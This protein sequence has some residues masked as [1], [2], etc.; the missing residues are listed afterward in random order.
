MSETPMSATS[1]PC[2]SSTLAVTGYDRTPTLM[3][4]ERDALRALASPVHRQRWR[5]R[6]EGGQLER[7]VTP[8]IDALAVLDTGHD[9]MEYGSADLVA[10]ELLRG[11]WRQRAA[12]WGWSRE[13]WVAELGTSS[14]EAAKRYP[15]VHRQT[16][17]ATAYVLGCFR[18]IWLLGRI[19]RQRLSRK[20]F[21]SAAV[22]ACIAA[23][24]QVVLSWG[25]GKS[26]GQGSIA[27]LALADAILLSGSPR[28]TDMTTDVLDALRR[29][30]GR[31]D[32]DAG[33]HVLHRVLHALEVVPAP[34]PPLRPWPITG[35]DPLW[36]EWVERWAR[37]STNQRATLRSMRTACLKAGRW[38]A[39]THP[40]VREPGEWTRETCA[41]WVAAVDR[42]RIGDFSIR[43]NPGYG[44]PVTAWTKAAYIGIL[45]AFLSDCQEWGWI[46]RR[47]DPGRALVTPRAVR[48]SLGPNPRVIDDAIWAKLLWAG[49][50]LGDADLR[51]GGH[52]PLELL[53]ALALCWLFSGSRSN[54]IVRLR[55]GCVRWQ[56][57]DGGEPVCLLDIPVTKTSTAFT[58]P[59]DPILGRALEEWERKR[60]AQPKLVD[61][62]TGER[63]AMLFALR[64]RPVAKNYLN[65]R[66]IPVL[67]AKAGVPERD[68]RGRI[69]SHRARATI[70]SHL[71]NAKEPL[72]LAELQQWLGHRSPE[73]TQYYAQL[74]P[75]TLSRAYRDAGYF[76]RNLRTIEVLI[77]RDAVDSGAA[78]SGKPW[79]YFDLGHG[80]C[81]YTFF[82]QCPH[83][84]ACARCDFYRPKPATAALIAEGRSNLE[85][86]LK[87]VPLTDDERAAIDE[88]A[89]ALAALIERLADVPTPAGPTPRELGFKLQALPMAATE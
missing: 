59:V 34:P 88:G 11:C 53:R 77:D 15:S 64:A 49:L 85:R 57:V 35:P 81:T 89:E 9:P 80:F 42:M 67:C 71:Y 7:L 78:A 26:A 56:A 68:V 27:H 76:A 30:P 51:W 16:A 86:L 1:A 17:I 73:V 75:T 20:I 82:E 10:L 55:V 33:V 45:R 38:L 46:E 12:Y 52:Y 69:T 84:M 2:R 5:H 72:S 22:N 21:G 13:I 50:N 48:N 44:A 79:R 29:V 66:L 63:V 6:R 87:E 28:L 3:K 70:A 41:D 40:E 25:Y 62:R 36:I 4:V 43:R 37:T 39:E 54:E 74:T 65:L 60:P 18:D 24:D 31:C 61:W 83:R 58:R 14:R 19:D 23:V 47:F 32:A 8:I